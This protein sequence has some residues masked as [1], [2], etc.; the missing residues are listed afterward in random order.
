MKRLVITITDGET[1]DCRGIKDYGVEGGVIG[2]WYG[3]DNTLTRKIFPLHNILEIT[4]Y[5]E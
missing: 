2:I 5:T 1:L 4:E 3:A